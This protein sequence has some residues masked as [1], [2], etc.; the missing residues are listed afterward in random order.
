MEET[1]DPFDWSID[2]VI[3]YLCHASFDSWAHSR[4]PPPRPK[5]DV[6]QK[7]LWENDV[8]GY[9]L[10]TEINK[11]T[12]IEDFGL[13]SLGQRTTILQAVQYLQGISQKYRD[14]AMTMVEIKPD[15]ESLYSPSKGHSQSPVACVMP[16]LKPAS[17][18][19]QASL[20]QTPHHETLG[21]Q[22]QNSLATN[23]HGKKQRR[24]DPSSLSTIQRTPCTRRYLDNQK[25]RV[26]DI[27]YNGV[28]AETE[29]DTFC[30][31]GSSI[32]PSGYQH[33]V[34][35]KMQYY[36]QQ[37]P[38]EI[39]SKSGNPSLA[40][41]PYSSV[42]LARDDTQFF[43]LFVKNGKKIEFSKENIIDWPEF[44]HE[45]DD[46]HFLLSKYPPKGEHD[47]LPTYGDSASEGS[48]DSE[49]WREIE[50]ECQEKKI[51]DNAKS[52]MLSAED[53]EAAIDECIV[54][55]IDK[56]HSEKL[57][58]EERKARPIWMQ[59]DRKRTR[60]ADINT[61]SSK[62]AH[63]D[64]RLK[65]LR[66]AIKANPWSQIKD[67]QM[68]CRSM[69]QT[70][71]ERELQRWI[72]TVLESKECPPK[73]VGHFP[74]AQ[75][76]P[77]RTDVLNDEESLG[78]DTND[79]L[80]SFVIPDEEHVATQFD[81]SDAG[82][83][84]PRPVK[85]LKLH[86][87]R[88]SLKRLEMPIPSSIITST[89]EVVDLTLSDEESF[90]DQDPGNETFEIHT[91]PLNP[92][93]D[94]HQRA[95][96]LSYF[97]D[98]LE[99]S[100]TTSTT[101]TPSTRVSD[102]DLK[103]VLDSG[104]EELQMCPTRLV[105]WYVHCI[106]STD[107]DG[108]KE[109]FNTKSFNFIKKIVLQGLRNMPQRI[110]VIEPY[111]IEA[112]H[113]WM[114]IVVMYISWTA[115][116]KLL[117]DKG[118]EKKDIES[119]ARK[120]KKLRQFLPLLAEILREYPFKNGNE[121]S[122]EASIE[123][124]GQATIDFDISDEN[125]I[126]PSASAHTPHSKRKRA[127]KQSQEALNT[128]KLAQRRVRLQEE[129]QE[130]LLQR[131]VRS[132]V[133]NSDPERQAVS[134]DEP[135][136]YLHSHI[137]SRVKM[138]QLHGI[139]FM[140]R[141]LINDEKR[142]GCLLAHTMGLGKTMQVIAL[143]VTIAN[144]ANSEDSETRNQIPE[145][146]RESRTLI[147]CPPS[148]I[149]NW[150][151]EF[152]MWTPQD[153]V[154]LKNLGFVRK[155]PTGLSLWERLREIAAWYSEG[156]VLLI[157][158]DIFRAMILNRA[159]KVRGSQFEPEQHNRIKK[160]L[161]EGPNIV[162]ADEAHKM[163]N[164]NTGI[165]EASSYF[166]TKS[167]I[168]LTGSPLANHLEEYYSMINWIAPGYLGDFVQFKA[169]Y[170]EPI[171]DG[172]Y[173]DSTPYERR[174][175]LKK[176]Q[177]L[178]NDLDPKVNRADISVL[179][180]DLPPKVEFV[181]TLPLTSLQEQ[182]YKL[183]VDYLM[184]DRDDVP[185]ARLWA[186]LAILSILC[187]HPSCFLEKLLKKNGHMKSKTPVQDSENDS[188]AEDTT[189]V[190][191]V[192]APEVINRLETLFK[193]IDELKSTVHSHRTKMLEEI[194]RESINAG[195]KILVFSHSIPTLNYIEHVLIQNGWRYSRLDGTTPIGSRQTATKNFNKANS[196]IQVYLIST[197][198]GGL[199]LNIPGANRVIIFDFAFNPTWEEQ[200]V[201]RA[202]RFGQRKPVFVYRFIA[203][204]T[205]EDAMYNKIVFKTQLSFRVVDKKNPIRYASKSKKAYL[206][207][208]KEVK[209]NDLTEFKGKDPKV[210]DK[211]LSQPNF[212]RQIA[213][214]ETF[215]R[216][217]ND[218]LTPE[219]EKAVQ[220]E[221][222]DERLKRN[223]PKAWEKKNAERE[224]IEMQTASSY[225]TINNIRFTQPS[226]RTP[227]P[228]PT[229]QP[230][231]RPVPFSA[232]SPTYPLN[233]GFNSHQGTIDSAPSASAPQPR[234]VHSGPPPLPPDI[235]LFAPIPPRP[236]NPS[237]T[238]SSL[239]IHV[240]SPTSNTISRTDPNSSL[241]GDTAL[242]TSR[243]PEIP[244][245]QTLD[246]S[247]PPLNTLQ[248]L[249]EM[250]DKPLTRLPQPPNGPKPPS[251][252]LP[253]NTTLSESQSP[254]NS[255]PPNPPESQIA[256]PPPSASSAGSHTNTL[257]PN[258]PNN[259]QNLSETL[260]RNRKGSNDTD[261]R[262]GEAPKS[263]DSSP[264]TPDVEDSTRCATQ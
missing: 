73:Q 160:Q 234:N 164:K 147:L 221:L 85:K 110:Y 228:P 152:L 233:A 3:S 158:Y 177:V 198:A 2:E 61:A 92:L 21:P 131:F 104:S 184:S 236:P 214:T 106:G 192:L 171:E 254:N 124:S 166:R 129:Q 204:G 89:V 207:P 94:L 78:S 38:H 132:G 173:I 253:E 74:V 223:D 52:K 77:Q 138:H 238:F 11:Q 161:L 172:L 18:K 169:K 109:I 220:A 93:D 229:I 230:V 8:T 16:I 26:S 54:S 58:A 256:P 209:Q 194:I 168:A 218:K 105:A 136:I 249:P 123:S 206:F 86:Q 125:D 96:S 47:A 259:N 149:E 91:P 64:Q 15:P 179:E 88:K 56:W 100:T 41:F 37:K 70:V 102:L 46:L 146:F 197:K 258:Q 216:E 154:T 55:F 145:C 205:Y 34:N 250:V 183:Y 83:E 42:F 80:D 87:G 45:N 63:L 189:P 50:M 188:L 103:R 128:Q 195:D 72:I 174:Q 119:A 75:P 120:K 232:H 6:L 71:F 239:S 255:G 141:E 76:K 191:Q 201:G 237:A 20:E 251:I 39:K 79:E 112:S 219:E 247:V 121:A 49:T 139:R 69:E 261:K 213:L 99:S 263:S 22:N 155:L 151:E 180:G 14:H 182:A 150:W 28:N 4:A 17:R 193:D 60:L 246:T 199:G 24:L 143:L 257:I 53:I 19:P 137:G 242:T 122:R 212:I 10:L 1:K 7:A 12:L 30:I 248:A 144:A 13:K 200:A 224:R 40:V 140:W 48:Y 23:I 142:Q 90:D 36:F 227:M 157:S 135:I 134:F 126:L 98:E 241:N 44:D 190:T 25:S 208:P 107:R 97:Q 159:T 260:P 196:P 181:I 235:S 186:W 165:S 264:K 59:A 62:I 225:M 185:N 226:P 245:A 222:D 211:L 130:R 217:D 31:L 33:F 81:Q 148:L 32:T 127:V 252:S 108:L 167:R 176:L 51:L 82:D 101:S 170:V 231:R 118:I 9:V 27:F 163:K 111:D 187:N 84:T 29:E 43:S 178:K 262:S 240:S 156:G 117:M 116:K 133:K 113:L 153:P 66:K 68:Q 244:T 65:G 162:I 215:Q 202:Y 203:G 114:R 115:R 210:L 57:P 5:P 67:I 35:Q 95:P 243:L 175:S